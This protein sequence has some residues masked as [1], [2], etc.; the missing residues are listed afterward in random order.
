MPQTAIKMTPVS[1]LSI[2]AIGYDDDTSTL[3]VQFDSGI[4]HYKGVS[5]EQHDALVNA[6]S[7][8]KHFH[9]HIKSQYAG[10][11]AA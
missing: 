5:P 1:S 2:K 8:G 6:E 11:K 7:I 3:A 9:L 10:Q 4:Y